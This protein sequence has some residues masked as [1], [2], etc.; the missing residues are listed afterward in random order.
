MNA[1]VTLSIGD[2][3]DSIGKITFPL[4]RDYARK[5]L[6]DCI[7]LDTPKLNLGFYH[8]EKLQ[9]FDL[10]ERYERII[11]LDNDLLMTPRCPNLFSVTP[12]EK[13]GAFRVS[14]YT[15][16]HDNA[17]RIV[18]D[19]LGEIGWGR[20]YFNSGVMVASRQH[21]EVFNKDNGLL[22]WI[23]RDTTGELFANQTYIN[24]LVKKFR[25]EVYDIGYKFNHLGHD[26]DGNTIAPKN[27][28]TR[29]RSYIIHYPGRG[30]RPGTKG[31]QIEKDARILRNRT[32]Y[33]TF[34]LC[35]FLVRATGNSIDHVSTLAQRIRR[36]RFLQRP[37]PLIKKYPKANSN[38]LSNVIDFAKLVPEGQL[39]QGWHNV[40]SGFRWMSKSAEVCL[41]NP[42]P[43]RQEKYRLAIKG[44][45]VLDYC[46]DH[47]QEV[48]LRI[49]DIVVGKNLLQKNGQH[50]IEIDFLGSF[51]ETLKLTIELSNS[52]IP[53]QHTNSSDSRDLGI[54]IA[55]IELL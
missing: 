49:N 33:L 48:T 53:M 1:V 7:V 20:G 6:A 38:R 8:Y 10:F 34:F 47:E 28:E 45:A 21:R 37:K 40:E 43:N 54:A 50:V 24:Y 22:K 44:T 5:I 51:P 36:W 32:L 2:E 12:R 15:K 11:F 41:L 55:S 26:F 29:F 18:Q 14:D 23:S 25:I 42:K 19:E 27:S 4:M 52:F 30:H 17:I 46:P 3:Y 35:P 9:I 39:L 31:E 16:L 13:F